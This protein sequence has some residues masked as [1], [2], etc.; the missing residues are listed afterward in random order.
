[1]TGERKV[2]NVVLYHGS[3]AELNSRDPNRQYTFADRL[4]FRHGPDNFLYHNIFF[5][6][7]IEKLREKGYAGIVNRKTSHS[8]ENS[9][10]GGG[11]ASLM[12]EG[13][14]IVRVRELDQE[15]TGETQ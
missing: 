15:K 3:L 1:M 7:L 5:E 6:G 2:E 9:R 4:S 13:T 8:V 11:V 14:P 10:N 12:V